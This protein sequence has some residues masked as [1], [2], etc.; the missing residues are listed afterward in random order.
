MTLTESLLVTVC[1]VLTDK[2]IFILKNISC[3]KKRQKK[4][5][6]TKLVRKTHRHWRLG[7]IRLKCSGGFVSLW[8]SWMGS[9]V[10]LLFLMHPLILS[11]YLHSPTPMYCFLFNLITLYFVIFLCYASESRLF[12]DEQCHQGGFQMVIGGGTGRSWERREQW[13]VLYVEGIFFK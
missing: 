9:W 2:V 12:Y 13:V 3:T 7:L 1:T 5:N 4:Q 11:L 10:G 8:D 6:K